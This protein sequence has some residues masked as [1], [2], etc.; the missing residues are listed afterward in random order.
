MSNS[1]S[2]SYSYSRDSD[3]GIEVFDWFC[4]GFFSW[5]IRFHFSV[6]LLEAR[7]NSCF[8]KEA[9][10]IW[11]KVIRCEKYLFSDI[12]WSISDRL[13]PFP[14]GVS[15]QNLEIKRDNQSDPSH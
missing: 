4:V 13:K 8:L 14:D 10:A 15:I 9:R 5:H 1:Y 12:V 2:Y 3:P 11:N 7:V 6:M